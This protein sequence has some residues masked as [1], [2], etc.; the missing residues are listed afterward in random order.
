M[1]QIELFTYLLY[2]KSFYY[3]QKKYQFYIELK[4]FALLEK[5]LIT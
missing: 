5:H 4:I 1:D 3:E 2:F